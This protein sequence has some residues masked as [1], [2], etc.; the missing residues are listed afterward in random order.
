MSTLPFDTH[1]FYTELVESRLAEK[2]AKAITKAISK[3]EMT[4]MDNLVTK[5]DLK[6]LALVIYDRF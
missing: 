2:T 1:A 5:H 4:K 3:I 6:E